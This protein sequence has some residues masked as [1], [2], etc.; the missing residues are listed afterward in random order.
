MNEVGASF[1]D[2]PA[3]HEIPVLRRTQGSRFMKGDFH[4]RV[5]E[6]PESD[7]RI[8]SWHVS[9]ARRVG[10]DSGSTPAT[11]AFAR[12]FQGAAAPW[13]GLCAQGARS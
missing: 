1:T 12:F 8:N 2:V 10:N 13:H 3:I 6:Y 4:V 7:T 11:A 9:C 5:R